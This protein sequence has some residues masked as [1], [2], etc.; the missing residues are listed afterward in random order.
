[1]RVWLDKIASATRNVPLRQD[2]RLVPTIAARAG[3]IV[4]GRVH[5]EKAVYNQLEDIH[6]RM[7]ALQ[8]GDVVA[9]VIGP[10]NALHGY[11]GVVPDSIQPG[12][13]LHMLNLGGVIGRCTSRHLDLGS[14]F[15]VEVLGSI[16]VFPDFGDRQG[17]PAHIGMNAIRADSAAI[18]DVPMVWV[19]GTCMNSGKTMAACRLIRELAR[20]GRAVASCKLTGVSLHRDT[21]AMRDFGARWAVSFTEAGTV[22]TGRES[23]VEVARVLLAHL[24]KE[25]PD[26]VV[27]ELGDG[28]LGE[29]GVAEIL[30]APD[31]KARVDVLVLCA[32][33]PVGVWGAHRL[34]MEE[35]DLRPDVVCGPA[36]DNAVGTAFIEERLGLR[37]LNARLSG[38]ELGA[39]V[40]ARLASRAAPAGRG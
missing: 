33:D 21:L 34:L 19:A 9:G 15:E 18:P 22:T 36:T 31:L 27:I 29:Y 13:R 28:L 4:A 23:A 38:E 14:P 40:A 11:C 26:V 8:E 16:L 7:T 5:G 37:A 17:V 6:G 30:K 32:N 12:E 24:G 20:R 39:W 2:A 3:Q 25:R 10:R 1:M 35:F